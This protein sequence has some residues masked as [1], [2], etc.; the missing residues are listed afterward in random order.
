MDNALQE[1]M[2]SKVKHKEQ[3]AVLTAMVK[4]D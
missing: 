2:S 3:V 4:S 1:I